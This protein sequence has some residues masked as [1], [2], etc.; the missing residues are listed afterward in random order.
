M[1]IIAERIERLREVEALEVAVLRAAIAWAP[2]GEK[3]AGAKVAM[4]KANQEIFAAQDAF[5]RAL[6]AVEARDEPLATE[7]FRLYNA[8]NLSRETVGSDG[9]ALVRDVISA[10]EALGKARTKAKEAQEASSAVHGASNIAWRDVL[11]A[12]DAFTAAASYADASGLARLVDRVRQ[13][14]PAG[15]AEGCKERLRVLGEKV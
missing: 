2:A 14:D 15:M 6:R 8:G 4:E 13:P 10:D 1:T 3:A 11:L 5:N 12:L 9:G 7:L